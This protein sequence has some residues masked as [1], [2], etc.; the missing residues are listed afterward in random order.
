MCLDQCGPMKTAFRERHE[1]LRYAKFV[2]V[3]RR[4]RQNPAMIDD[5]RAFLTHMQTDPHQRAYAD[6]W[7]AVLALPVEMIIDK[8]L[9]D[10][11]EGDLLRDTAPPFGR[12]FSSREVAD[13]IDR[14]HA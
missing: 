12:G 3:S 2:E 9:A 11:P 6:R 14:L 1:Q 10:S 7:I 13:L 8:L 4:L 5:A